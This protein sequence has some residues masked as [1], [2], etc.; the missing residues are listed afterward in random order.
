MPFGVIQ[1]TECDGRATHFSPGEK[2]RIEHEDGSLLHWVRGENSTTAQFS[3][4]VVAST[5]KTF[6]Y[7]F[8][9][10]L[11]R[12]LKPLE[13]IAE[14]ASHGRAAIHMKEHPLTEVVLWT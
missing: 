14:Y 12:E 2:I 4:D 11:I 1:I 10:L 3:R 7:R 8:H 13:L 9:K 5:P 6:S